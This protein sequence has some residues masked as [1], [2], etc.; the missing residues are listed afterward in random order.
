MTLRIARY[1][2][3]RPWALYDGSEL[4]V[5]TVYRRGA[6]EVQ[7]RLA[8]SAASPAGPRHPRRHRARLAAA[9]ARSSP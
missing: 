8:A 6:R 2:H 9:A 7:R 4:V 3:T 5:V 1:K